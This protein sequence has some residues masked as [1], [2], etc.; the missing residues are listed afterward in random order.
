[1]TNPFQKATKKESLLRM[2]ITGPSGGGK[3]YTALTI[4]AALIPSAK[5]ALIDTE[6]GSASKYA[7]QF[8]FDVLELDDFRPAVYV[9][10]IEAAQANGYN[11]LIID[12]LSHAW[13]A[14]GGVLSIVDDEA[15]RSKTGNTFMA[16]RKGTEV[17]NQLVDAILASKMHVIATMRSKMEYVIETDSRG[18]QVPRKIGLA[19]VQRDGVEYEFDVVAEMDITNTMLVQKSRCPALTNAVIE[20]PGADVAATLRAWLSD[21]DPAPAPIAKKPAAE[22]PENI[23]KCPNCGALTESAWIADGR[24]PNCEDVSTPTGSP[25]PDSEAQPTTRGERSTHNPPKPSV[26]DELPPAAHWT[27]EPG[28]INKMVAWAREQVWDGIELP[29]ARNRVAKALGV[30]NFASIAAE[31]RG[32]KQ[33][34]MAAIQAYVPSDDREAAPA[35]QPQLVE[36]PVPADTPQKRWKAG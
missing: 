7:D 30:T 2:A 20:R 27:H 15:A 16:W 34:A 23:V 8:S 32:T 25:T 28:R 4:G 21:G 13:F 14:Q 24:C 1:M 31:Y 3:T 22:E 29:H 18:K 10:A 5:V 17:Q 35:E 9:R 26:A 12:S 11:V 19:P 6:R 33:E 36:V